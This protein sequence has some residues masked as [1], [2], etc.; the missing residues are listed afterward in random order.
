MEGKGEGKGEEKK[1]GIGRKN[2]GQ[3]WKG[4][5]EGDSNVRAERQEE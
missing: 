1:K 3:R 4:V 5:D 2:W